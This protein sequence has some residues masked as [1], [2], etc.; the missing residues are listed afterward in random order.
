M[1]LFKSIFVFAVIMLQWN[2]NL[3]LLKRI[4]FTLEGIF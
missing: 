2:L 1:F 4:I 3:P